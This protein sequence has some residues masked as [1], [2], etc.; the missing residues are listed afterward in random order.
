MK[1]GVRPAAQARH[2]ATKVNVVFNGDAAAV[3]GLLGGLLE[4]QS[5]RYC[6]WRLA[7]CE[8]GIVQRLKVPATLSD[9]ATMIDWM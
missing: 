7:T 2:D 9:G 4:V 8:G 5:R 3:E 6:N 1:L